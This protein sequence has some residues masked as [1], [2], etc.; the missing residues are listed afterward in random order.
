M[1]SYYRMCSLIMY[2]CSR[3]GTGVVPGAVTVRAGDVPRTVQ[4]K[5]KKPQPSTLNPQPSTLP[6]TPYTYTGRSPHEHAPRE[7]YYRMCSLTIECVPLL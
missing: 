6:P 3:S 1:Y 4:Y 5:F 2:R 7:S